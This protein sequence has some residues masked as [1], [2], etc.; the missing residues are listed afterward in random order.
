[1]LQTAARTTSRERQKSTAVNEAVENG[2]EKVCLINGN[3][4]QCKSTYGI[5]GFCTI[6]V[7]QFSRDGDRKASESQ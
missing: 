6:R 4:N 3:E 2:F 1:M 5:C 7:I